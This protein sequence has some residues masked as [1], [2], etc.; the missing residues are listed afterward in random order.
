VLA[1]LA[2]ALPGA[3]GLVVGTPRLVIG[4]P[5]LVVATSRLVVGTSR[6]VVGIS[7]HVVGPPRFSHNSHRRTQVLLRTPK[8]HSGAPRCSHTYHNYSHRTPVPV[9]RDPGHSEGWPEYPAA[10]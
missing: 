2:L 1:D 6:L 8:V 4:A 7:R 5:R 9:I 3:P 10:V